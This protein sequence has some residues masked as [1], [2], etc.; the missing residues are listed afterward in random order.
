MRFFMLQ[1]KIINVNLLIKILEFN[2]SISIL[3]TFEILVSNLVLI[4]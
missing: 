3:K 1:I 4:R 2:I